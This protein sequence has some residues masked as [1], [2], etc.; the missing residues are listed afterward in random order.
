MKRKTILI[1]VIS[2]VLFLTVWVI[3]YTYLNHRIKNIERQGFI[4]DARSFL[5]SDQE[6]VETYGSIS[7]FETDTNYPIEYDD[8]SDYKKWYMDFDCSTEK[9]QF[10]MRIYQV[11][12]KGSYRFE[13][14]EIE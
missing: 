3:G 9:G 11:F 12:D 10:R 5:N 13:Y 14:E 6:F 8:D 1:I 2:A 7:S 4:D